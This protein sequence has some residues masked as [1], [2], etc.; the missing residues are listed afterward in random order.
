MRVAGAS[1]SEQVLPFASRIVTLVSLVST[2]SKPALV[3]PFQ[4]S[5]LVPTL[6][7]RRPMKALL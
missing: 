5:V 4:L 3:Q 7:M 1:S 6:S 2:T